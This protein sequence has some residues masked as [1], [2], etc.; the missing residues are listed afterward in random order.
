M[1]ARR[2]SGDSAYNGRPAPVSHDAVEAELLQRNR[3]A[4][5]A[6]FR[7]GYTQR[8][9]ESAGWPPLASMLGRELWHMV[10]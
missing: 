6:F 2:Y 5:N 4:F 7:A 9:S 3:Y 10:Y 8:H 1:C